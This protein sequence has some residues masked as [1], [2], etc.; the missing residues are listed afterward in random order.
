MAAAIAQALFPHFLSQT[1]QAIIDGQNAGS[2]S[3][4]TFSRPLFFLLLAGLAEAICASLRGAFFIVIGS[5]TSARL[6]QRLF[7]SLLVQD[8]GFF[9]TTKT[10]EITAR[11]TQDCQR[12]ANDVAFNVNFFSRTVV[13][14]VTT[15]CFML[16]YSRELTLVSFVSVPLIVILSKKYGRFMQHLSERTQQQ[17]AEANAVAE[18]ALSSIATVRS[19]AA[20]GS[21]AERFASR[22]QDYKKLERK[23]ANYYVSYLTTTIVLPLLGTCFVLFQVGRLCMDGLHGPA[24]LAFVFYLQTL[25]DCFSSLAD[26]YTSM[27][28]ALG[29]ATRVFELVDR[30]PE[31]S[32]QICLLPEKKQDAAT[33]EQGGDMHHG[34]HHDHTTSR[35]ELLNVSFSYPARPNQ[36][37]LENL[38]LDC[39][40]GQSVALVG[41]S[42]GGKSTC[43]RLFQRFYEPSEGAV[44]LGGKDVRTYGHSEFHEVVSTVGQEPVLFGRSVRENILYGLPEDHPARARPD[45]E[46]HKDPGSEVLRAATLANAHSFICSMPEG[47]DTEVGERGVQ[48]SGGQKQRISIARALVRRPRVL[49]LDEATSALDAE[50]E[51]LVQRA[52]NNLISQQEMTVVIV[53]HRLSTVQ[54][55]DKICVVGKGKVLEEGSHEQLLA[56]PDGHYRQLVDRQLQ[57]LEE[58]LTKVVA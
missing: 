6:R 32:T 12:A 10:G 40:P 56:I 9:D 29:S 46:N 28:Q 44:L 4:A 41:P 42:G 38:S 31:S 25:N 34:Q 11:L 37:V 3:Y 48:L 13:R 47:Y 24:L 43:M 33:A 23:R 45:P 50:S 8:L 19:F 53:A 21:E 49:L 22:L 5:R 2:L 15:L 35:L 14:L 26:F 36:Q 20:E 55:A 18:E 39:P 54:K 58:E 1:L 30:K 17:L 51:A 27:T 57:G 16:Y 7:R 52:I